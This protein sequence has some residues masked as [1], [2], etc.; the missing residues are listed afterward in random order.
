MTLKQAGLYIRPIKMYMVPT[1]DRKMVTQISKSTKEKGGIAD[2]RNS[3]LFL[4]LFLPHPSSND[5]SRTPH[6]L[7]PQRPYAPTKLITLFPQI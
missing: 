6:Y 7:A 2:H 3:R 1:I 4:S 5:L